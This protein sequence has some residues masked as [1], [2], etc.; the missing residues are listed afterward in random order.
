MKRTLFSTAMLATCATV[1][2]GMLLGDQPAPEAP[3]GFDGLTN[4]SIAQTEM[5][6]D[7]A[8][9]SEIDQPTP[10]GLGPVYNSVSCLDCH[11]SVAIGGASQVLEFR[12]G[13]ND[14]SRPSWF[15]SRR[16]PFDTNG[17][18]GTFVAATAITANG[19]PIADRSLINQR[20]I[21]ADAV[22]HLT[23]ADNIRASRLSLSVL[24]DGFVEAVPDSTFLAL[25][26]SNHGE[27]IE[28]PV[29]EANGIT[30]IGK[31]GWKDQHASLLSFSGDAYVNEIG[32]TNRL[33]PDESTAVCEPS[34]GLTTPNDTGNDIDQFA[35]FMRASKVPP[36]GPITLA[37]M[38]GQAIFE[39]IG[40]NNC[41]V[42]TLLTAEAGT[43]IH[44]GTFIVPEALGGKQIHPFGDYL[45][46]DI[47]TGDGIVQNGP[48]D[49][50]Y[51]LRTMP[52]WGLRTR[53]QL[54]HDAQS[55]TYADAIGR[56]AGEAAGEAAKFNQLTP[57]QKSLLYAFLG[58]L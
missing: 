53:T 11:Q 41:H 27:A 56:H 14:G 51:K 38:Q 28:V 52:L 13:H 19:T 12:A 54:M 17:S 21:C 26:A 15:V 23:D 34:S 42:E 35:A 29:L 9:F 33:F 47:G 10:D 1:G 57:A 43:P 55:A 48:A 49:T 7:V 30:E 3:A 45:L 16:H 40:C 24:G 22:E 39:Q 50:Q 58:S 20:A 46:H 18:T 36:R 25:A 2:I 32:V 44:G 5:D 37:V 8:T 6:A 31:F 4:G